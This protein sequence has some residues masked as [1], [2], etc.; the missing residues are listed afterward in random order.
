M[1]NKKSYPHKGYH[2]QRMK[3]DINNSCLIYIRWK[4]KIEK[5][6]Q[7]ADE[8]NKSWGWVENYSDKNIEF[9]KDSYLKGHLG[10]SAVER[11]P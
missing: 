11:L 7:N 2:L 1:E 6:L 4:E 3:T 9:T 8:E 10:C 5:H